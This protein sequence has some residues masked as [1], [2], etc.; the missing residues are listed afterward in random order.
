MMKMVRKNIK[1]VWCLNL[2]R[3]SIQITFCC[4]ILTAYIQVL[5]GST[6]SVLVLSIDLN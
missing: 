3:D 5:S 1:E 2:K 4:W 6:M